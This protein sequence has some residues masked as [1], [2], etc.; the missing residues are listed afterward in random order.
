MAWKVGFFETFLQN[1]NLIT[2]IARIFVLRRQY[3]TILTASWISVLS[4]NWAITRN[5][6]SRRARERGTWERGNSVYKMAARQV[7]GKTPGMFAGGIIDDLPDQFKKNGI[8]QKWLT[9]MARMTRTVA[10]VAR[11]FGWPNS[12]GY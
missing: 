11:R 2:R 4:R 1:K 7:A 6:A 10:R 12:I 8:T 9:G 5:T 3:C